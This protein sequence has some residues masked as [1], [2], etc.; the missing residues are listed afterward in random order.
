MAAAVHRTG[1]DRAPWHPEHALTAAEALA[2][3]T[4]RQ[5]TLRPGSRGDVVLLDHDPLAAYGETAAVAAHLR[6]MG[7][8]ATF[9]AGRPTHLAL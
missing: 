4:D 5:A 1:D 2:A 8:A 3:S 6:R 7:V 9:V